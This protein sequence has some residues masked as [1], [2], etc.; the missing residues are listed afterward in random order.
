M[1]L[2]QCYSR[3]LK[4]TRRD[5]PE[6]RKQA[7]DGRKLSQLLPRDLDQALRLG[8][9][10]ATNAQ[11][12]ELVR[13]GK[14]VHYT[15]SQGN[16]D[17]PEAIRDHWPANV[18]HSLYWTSDG[19]SEI[20]RAEAFVRIWRQTV[21]LAGLTLSDWVSMRT[22]FAGDILGGRDQ[23]EE[24][25]QPGR[26]ERG[27]FERKLHLLF[28]NRASAFA[29]P[30]DAA[31]LEM[32]RAL[33]GAAANLRHAVFH[34]KGR[35]TLLH[36]LANL[37]ARLPAPV[38]ESARHIWRAD[39][40]D[41]TA[42]LKAVL[43]AADVEHFLGTD[44]L[45]QVVQLLAADAPAEPPLPRFSR[46]LQRAAGAWADDK[47]IRLPE[48]A[49]RRALQD[50]ARLCQ[51]TVLKLVYE[52]SFRSWLRT[53]RADTI[54]G[55]IDV[56]VGRTTEAAR[57]MNAKG[58]ETGKKVIAAR[59]RDL[60]KPSAG[61]DIIDFFF[62]L[63]AE[64]ASEMRV[65]RG[66][67]SDGEKARE[68]A[69]YID[70]LQ[71]DVL[72]LSFS[73]FLC[74]QK[75]EWLLD[76][77]PGQA[78][79]GQPAVLDDLQSAAP[80]TDA[81][82]W[83]TALYLL[84]HLVPVE[85][86]G[87]LLHQLAKWNVTASRASRLP[88]D[89]ETRLRRLGHTM[90]LY[91][92]MHDAKF[93][94]GSALGQH[95]LQDLFESA[96]LM[97]RVLP[98]DPGADTDRR[99]PQRGLRE[100]MRFGHIPLLRML[101]RDRKIDAGTVERVFAA[102]QPLDGGLS[103]IARWQE[104]REQ[105]HEQWVKEKQ[106]D[107]TRLREYCEVLSSISRHRQDSNFVN[108]VDHVRAH[109]LVM[110]VLGRLVDYAGLFE[111]DLY[112][113]TLA[114][115]HRKGLRPEHLFEDDG[116]RLLFRGQII[117]ALRKHKASPEALEILGELAK[118]FSEVWAAGNPNA[119]IRNKLA[120]LNMVQGASPAPRLTHWVNRT[121]QLLAY[122][123]KLKN[124]VSK[125]VIELLAREGMELRWTMKTDGTAHELVEARLSA[126]CA[127]HLGGKRLA[128]AD[129]GPR[130]ATVFIDESLHSDG[131]VSMVAEAFEGRGQQAASIQ[132]NLLRV[133]WEASAEGIKDRRSSFDARPARRSPERQRHPPRGAPGPTASPQPRARE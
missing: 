22:A 113:A 2:K 129:T 133:D 104:R 24:A 52:R 74:E 99:I 58:D 60:P 56:A 111:R 97:D 55:W 130:P 10:Q 27:H 34:F 121:R 88:H 7:R 83:V 114:L 40:A 63:S 70:H 35:G 94:G 107:Q 87:R 128:L 8:D 64:T 12:G 3:L 122:D 54:S 118:H 20:K 127:R 26:F 102:E 51:Y 79:T 106:F 50:P 98:K 78:S 21:V 103:Q 91:L 42:R 125:S 120:H 9:R 89:E 33:I 16:A 62:D 59:A 43:R 115:L 11:L 17:R 49:N 57:R 126:R 81:E 28:G 123:R 32:L 82:E 75:L 5:T 95:D 6:H 37:P 39:A 101:S 38:R 65:Q 67:E 13:L 80:V 110:A 29:L 76:L 92:D 4:R 84:L 14:I 18:E 96:A 30:D 105:L 47:R 131:F 45:A 73:Q 23:L 66:Y 41:R 132:Q 44:Q 48:P 68:Q 93:E 90:T 69:E 1:A 108:L 71:R 109:R 36:E 72:I 119:G 85:S 19:Q 124:A 117:F 77:Q 112:F 25:L 86:V 116:L 31:C 46:L 15:A 61:G 53:Q 100:I